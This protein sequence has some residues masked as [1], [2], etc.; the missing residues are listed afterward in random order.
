ML[1]VLLK[2]RAGIIAPLVAFAAYAIYRENRKGKPD[3]PD[4]RRLK[5]S[6]SSRSRFKPAH[7]AGTMPGPYELSS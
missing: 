2:S 3:D 7:R 6:A 1:P 5:R 4:E